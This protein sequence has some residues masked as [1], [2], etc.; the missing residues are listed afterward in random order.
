MG[1]DKD[2][3]LGYIILDPSGLQ[4]ETRL[5]SPIVL[6]RREL[7]RRVPWLR[8]KLLVQPAIIACSFKSVFQFRPVP[9]SVIFSF[10]SP[11]PIG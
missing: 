5:A 1:T 10:E 8:M 4:E 11:I 6:A 7:A 3:A 9:N 2:V